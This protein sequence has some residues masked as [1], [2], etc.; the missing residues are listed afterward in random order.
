VRDLLFSSI[1]PRSNHV[2]RYHHPKLTPIPL[3][4][5]F[6]IMTARA[7]L[8]TLLFLLSVIPAAAKDSWVEVRSPHFIVYS[9]SGEHDARRTAAQ[10][11]EFRELFH[12]ALPNMRI[13][14]N[15]PVVIFAVKNE[16]NMKTFLPAYW[17]TKDHVH[18]AGIYLNGEDKH[19]VLLRLD[20]EGQ[21]PYEVIYHEY[22]HALMA[23]NFRDLPVWLNEGLAEFF[24]NSHLDEKESGFGLPPRGLV[25]ELRTNTLI[26]METLLQV[27]HNSP[28]Y[29]ERDR[30]N[31]FYAQSWATVHYLMLDENARKQQLFGK[32]LTAWDS[33]ESQVEA[34]QK[35]FGDLKKFGQAVES[36]VR[37]GN[38][39]YEKIKLTLTS[40]PKSYTARP[41]PDAEIDAAMGEFYTRMNRPT[42][43]KA[44]L[45][46]ALKADP[47]LAETHFALGQL[48]FSQHDLPTAQTEYSKAVELN[49][50]NFL[51]YFALARSQ[52]WN[53]GIRNSETAQRQI[54]SL[55]KAVEIN[56]NFAPA[57][58]LL[59]SVYSHN[60][61]TYKQAIEAG[62][63]AV[64]LEPGTLY[65]AV[66]FGYVLLN[67][68][69]IADARRLRDKIAAAAST[70]EDRNL[71][72]KLSDAINSRE[73][74]EAD[75]NANNKLAASGTAQVT[76]QDIHITPSN[77]D[78]APK[79]VTPPSSNSQ[80][81][82][83]PPAGKPTSAQGSS[84]Q[85]APA[86]SNSTPN[87]QSS[88]APGT[89]KPATTPPDDSTSAPPSLGKYNNT[90]QSQSQSQTQQTTAVPAHPLTYIP[91]PPPAEV[92]HA[93]IGSNPTPTA[94]KDYSLVGKILSADCTA[95]AGKLTLLINSIQMNFHFADANS[96]NVTAANKP[97]PPSCPAWKNQRAKLTFTPATNSDYDGDLTAIQF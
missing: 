87:S 74:F 79:P 49:T 7:S 60:P 27:D 21:N 34:A 96:V 54:A 4:I 13:E 71:A 77:P 3:R 41:L 37:A 53:G 81:A 22:T 14:L 89:T 11:E 83:S 32:F 88:S 52:V 91:P 42:E 20:I 16:G 67:T 61:E 63:K 84:T 94:D 46:S 45:D 5:I 31:V 17:E 57:W 43:A 23:L 58:S 24:G 97:K 39:Q 76:S 33:G 64:L 48:A 36:Y 26:P 70:P 30:T 82:S 10:F 55:Q 56:P 92:H 90:P 68:H 51:A 25:Y 9:N 75:R 86:Q 44:S 95:G 18:P 50:N 15:K 62:R 73:M 93:A 38:F 66:N 1:D 6:N 29:N 59:A 12:A 28:Y 85:S 78:A 19:M 69:N 8:V 80:S 72:I 47:N 65:Y 35:T 40:D 2:T